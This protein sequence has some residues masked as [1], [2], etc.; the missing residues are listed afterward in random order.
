[1]LYVIGVITFPAGWDAE[2]VLQL[3]GDG[4][5]KYNP[6]DCQIGWAYILI[7][8]GTAVGLVAAALSFSA[9]LKR[10]KV[11]EPAYAI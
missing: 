10:R 1:M 8:S 11:Q 5:T 7:I 3:C 9:G 4:A 2:Q 6:G